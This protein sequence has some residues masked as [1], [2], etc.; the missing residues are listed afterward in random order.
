MAHQIFS[1][2]A[3]LHDYL[4]QEARPGVLTLVPHQ[5]LARQVWHRQR[6]RHLEQGLAAWEPL[7][8][9]TLG[10]WWADLCQSLWLPQ[11]VASPLKRLACWRTALETGPPLEGVEPDL[12]WAQAL[13]EAYSLLTRHRLP[14][15]ESDP[16][17]S[18]LVSWRRQLMGLFQEMM[19]QEG[20]LAPGE[21][22]VYLL[23]GLEVGKITLPTRLLTVGL[24]TPAPVED[25]WLQAVARHIPV[26]HLRAQGTPDAVRQAVVLPDRRQEVEW[27]A[28]RL[29]ELAAAGT[30]LHRL[31]LTSPDLNSYLPELRR[32]WA[33]LL[34]TPA[35]PEGWAYNFSQ[36]PV[37]ADTPLWQAALLPLKFAG[38]GE[39]GEDLVSLLLSPYYGAFQAHQEQL[40]LWDRL[41]RER[42]VERGWQALSR[43]AAQT[44][45]PPE[46]LTLLDRVWQLLAPGPAP[47]RDW[48]AR[49][50]KAWRLLGFPQGLEDSEAAAWSRATA[51]L[52]EVERALARTALTAPEFREWLNLGA[53]QILLPGEGVQDAGLQIMGLLE[54]RGLDFGQV[55]CLGMN[56]GVF[57]PPPRPLP[58]L[59]P[60]EKQKVLGGTYQSQHHFA[61]ELF[62]TVLAG[63]PEITLTRPRT[64]DQEEC[65]GTSMFLGKWEEAQLSPL[66]RPH[67]AWLR[68]AAVRAVFTP[69]ASR[70]LPAETEAPVSCSLPAEVSLT[71]AQVARSCA[72]RFLLE[73]LLNI[74]ELPEIESGLSPAERGDLLHKVLARFAGEFNQLLEQNP[75]W[76]EALRVQAQEMLT[77]TA[78]LLL[79]DRLSDLHWQAELDRWLGPEGLLWEWLDRERERYEQ[80]WR[81][82][83]L[84]ERFQDLMGP[85]WPFRLKGRIDRIDAHPDA[86]LMLW[87]YKTGKIPGVKKVFDEGGEFQLPGYLAAVQQGQVEAAKGE[88]ALKAGFIGLK[89]ARQKDLQHE[90]FPKR[91]GEWQRVVAEWVESLTALGRRLAAGDF[92]PEPFPAPQ[93]KDK[94]ACEY[95]PY[96]LLCGFIPPE[97]PEDEEEGE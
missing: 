16:L 97:V 60:Q 29:L 67:P 57:P 5:R 30:P 92:S 10:H 45:G 65:V 48:A 4:L 64:A 78:R 9:T 20:F 66:S 12:S 24:E 6:L 13:D 47:A 35:S 52:A 82:L 76:D 42:R 83:A 56:S 27:A 73:V 81:W 77:A 33:E 75:E 1:T 44:G 53:R 93:G 49:L 38:A 59:S 37:L 89:S 91:A 80:G 62:D 94:G 32:A 22:P 86:G 72:C 23:Q 40:P 88:A 18:P 31:A 68:S 28:A 71:Q 21:L 7:P 43:V 19:R 2:S 41:F 87:D 25:L 36:G 74:R 58:L 11:A 46:A 34:G 55:I 95:C 26:M 69:P 96:L 8:L 63:A 85:D 14:L 61:R 79:K 15:L 3:A 17:D 54:M 50:Q 51:L 84:E 70:A 39:L 90:D